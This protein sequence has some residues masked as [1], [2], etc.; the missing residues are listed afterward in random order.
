MG[1][2]IALGG[3]AEQRDTLVSRSDPADVGCVMLQGGWEKKVKSRLEI[4]Y[5]SPL[6]LWVASR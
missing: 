2:R 1:R 3:L 6:M 5:R 4:N